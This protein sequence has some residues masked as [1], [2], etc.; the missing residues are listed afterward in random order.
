M[1][2]LV[3]ALL[4]SGLYGAERSRIPVSLVYADPTGEVSCFIGFPGH[5]KNAGEAT[6]CFLVFLPPLLRSRRQGFG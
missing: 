1:L 3:V 4:V 2:S 6:L 5:L